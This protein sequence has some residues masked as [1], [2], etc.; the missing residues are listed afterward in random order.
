MIFR[1][2]LGTL[3]LF[4]VAFLGTIIGSWIVSETR[5][6]KFLERHVLTPVVRPGDEILIQLVNYR[7]IRCP[8]T[9]YR[10]INYPNE[11]RDVIVQRL[12]ETFGKLGL[13]KYVV[14]LRTKDNASFG[15]GHVYSYTES[16]CN[17]WQMWW[18]KVSGP[19]VDEIEFGPETKYVR[20]ED[21]PNTLAKQ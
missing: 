21:A 4:F 6:V 14:N 17:P 2:F 8:Q 1:R 10:T 9:V 11:T 12:P 13:D 19:W 20:P 16:M 15:K 3:G 5:P 18:P 7:E